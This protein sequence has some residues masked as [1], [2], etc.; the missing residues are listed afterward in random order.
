MEGEEEN[1]AIRCGKGRS[2][3]LEIAGQARAGVTDRCITST[4]I[5][6]TA[7]GTRK[8]EGRVV[9][10]RS[11]PSSRRPETFPIF[12]QIVHLQSSR[13]RSK[14]R[15]IQQVS[16]LAWVNLDLD[17]PVTFPS[18][19]AYSVYLSSAQADSAMEQSKSKYIKPT[20]FRD[21]LNNPVEWSGIAC[22]QLLRMLCCHPIS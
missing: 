13:M 21:L 6:V 5:E 16:D 17:V 11:S 18:C 12:L 1:N 9:R 22:L 10:I 20:L 15:V 19:S 4:T 8:E 7:E 2:S 14:Y 3:G